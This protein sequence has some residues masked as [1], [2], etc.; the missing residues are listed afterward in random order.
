MRNLGNR[1]DKWF[2]QNA[3]VP[4]SL[5]HGSLFITNNK[6]INLSIPLK[7]NIYTIFNFDPNNFDLRLHS[8]LGMVTSYI[9]RPYACGLLCT[10]LLSRNALRRNFS[11][12]FLTHKQGKK[13]K[14][15]SRNWVKAL[16]SATSM[17]NYS[18]QMIFYS[19]CNEKKV[20]NHPWEIILWIFPLLS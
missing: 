8:F 13:K 1:N 7:A 11:N 16:C 4:L 18:S 20:H 17:S 12:D 5:E 14:K 3:R 15:T 2:V 19:S 6:P 10:C 9:K